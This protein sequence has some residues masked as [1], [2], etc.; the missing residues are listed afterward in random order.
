MISHEE[1]MNIIL[2]DAIETNMPQPTETIDSLRT[3]LAQEQAKVASWRDALTEILEYWNGGRES[4]Y[5]AATA[6]S[7]IADRAL[8]E[9]PASSLKAILEPTV[10][11]LKLI[12]GC[13]LGCTACKPK[14]K[15]EIDRLLRV[16]GG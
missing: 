10:E 9:S 4:A 8:K 13:P 1:M 14:A 16:G 2:T 3:Q 5:D 15:E 7:D 6:M 11:L 12:S